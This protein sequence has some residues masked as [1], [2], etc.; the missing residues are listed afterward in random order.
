MVMCH[1]L[2]GLE[3]PLKLSRATFFFFFLNF[4]TMG[5][6]SVLWLGNTVGAAAVGYAGPECGVAM[7]EG[8]LSPRA[9]LF[10]VLSLIAKSTPSPYQA[11]KVQLPTGGVS[12]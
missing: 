2:V 5:S 7:S 12:Q 8:M 6:E 10:R 4:K 9:G 3:H 1:L 11:T